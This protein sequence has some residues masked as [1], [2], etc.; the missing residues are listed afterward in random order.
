MMH[1]MEMDKKTLL[2][3]LNAIGDGVI[4][5]DPEGRI[6]LINAE[7]ERLTGEQPAD[8]CGHKLTEVM[9]VVDASTRKPCENLV[10]A[11]TA[12]HATI[13]LPS[14]ALLI[15][16]HGKEKRITGHGSPV[17]DAERRLT[18]VVVVLRDATDQT[19]IQEHLRQSDRLETLSVL[20]GGIAHDLNNMCAVIIGNVSYA[21]STAQQNSELFRILQQ[22]NGGAESTRDLAYQLLTLSKGGA[23]TKSTDG[24]NELIR[25][26]CRFA[27]RG[28]KS[29]CQYRLLK[30]LWRCDIDRGQLEQVVCN[31]ILNADQAMPDGGVVTISSDNV[32]MHDEAES[33]L[34]A[35]R[36]VCLTFEDNGI[37]IPE[38][39][40]AQIYD[41]FF[42]TKQTGNGLGIPTVHSIIKQH[43]GHMDISSIVDE[44]TVIHIYL[45]ASET[46][47]AIR[48]ETNHT[49]HTGSGLV[50]VLDDNDMVLRMA[51]MLLE[52][53]GYDPVCVRDGRDA[54]E[55]YRLAMDKRTPFKLLLL[56]LTIPGGMGGDKTIR[57]LREIDPGVKAIVSSGHGSDPIMSNYAELGFCAAIAKPYTLAQLS[58]VLNQV[59][60]P[61]VN[62]GP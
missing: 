27:L 38:Q 20:A 45:P 30:D 1:D 51:R 48:S 12:K 5:T 25:E 34:P 55:A 29:T 40:R 35:G 17:F 57:A 22:I 53:M 16:R 23:F 21:L 14:Q 37:G 6:V 43:G 46:P 60:A 52:H 4:T 28:S 11:V 47:T 2:V 26:T 49:P 18:G 33:S 13:E 42:T 41:P 32:E 3:T 50:L 39:N 44:G 59:F 15:D 62:E 31:I 8:A 19:R 24:I 56:D 58:Q 7:A 54:I 10:T 61:G 36:Y 9:L